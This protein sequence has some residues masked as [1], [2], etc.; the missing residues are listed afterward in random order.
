M[1]DFL[2]SVTPGMM[3]RYQYAH[4]LL[5]WAQ[6]S[7]KEI[8]DHPATVGYPLVEPMLLS[9]LEKVAHEIGSVP[10][11]QFAIK[12]T[13]LNERLKKTN[14]DAGNTERVFDTFFTLQDDVPR[15]DA[16]VK[17]SLT[18]YAAKSIGLFVLLAA[19]VVFSVLSLMRCA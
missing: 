13:E 5:K 15:L 2:L 1:K 6:N 10:L 14:E 11:L 18:A 12:L 8:K 17:K 7:V 9:S 19:L 3:V 16:E 4:D